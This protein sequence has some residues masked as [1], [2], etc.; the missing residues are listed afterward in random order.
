M[1]L[2]RFLLCLLL[3]PATLCAADL[4]YFRYPAI[5][6][7][8]LVFTAEGDVWV[9]DAAGGYGGRL[10][11]HPTLEYRKAI[12]PDG[13]WLAFNAGYEGPTEVYVM[14]VSGGPPKRLTFDDSY[15]QV[16]GWTPDGKILGS[17]THY[18]AHRRNMQLIEIDPE[19]TSQTLI[20]LAQAAEGAWNDHKSALYF[21]RF[22][23]QSSSTKRYK[24]G[25]AQNLWKWVPGSQE[26]IPLTADY[27]GTSRSPM[28]CQGRCYFVSDRDDTM[29]LWSMNADGGDLRQHTRHDNFDV[30]EP[31]LGQ[32]R[33]VY[34][35]GADLR[36][37]HIA[38]D[39]DRRVE[40][41]L[42]SDFLQTREKWIEEPVK[43]LS[44]MAISP[45]GDQLALVSRGQLFVTPVNGGRIQPISRKQGVRYRDVSFSHDGNSLI[46]VS[47][48]SGDYEFWQ[49]D[50]SGVD[51]R[52]QLTKDGHVLRFDPLVSPDGSRIVW[53][54]KNLKLWTYDF[55]TEHSEQIASSIHYSFGT[56]TYSPNGK[57]LAWSANDENEFSR[58]WIY[59]FETKE[60]H[61]LTSDRIDAHSPAW[62]R[63]GNRLFFVVDQ[64]LAS[65]V[66]SPW[67]MRQ[68]E[69]FFD[70][71][72]YI[73]ELPLK[74]GLRSIYE[75]PNEANRKFK[76]VVSKDYDFK[77]LALRMKRVPVPAG[78]Y[79]DLTA[80]A[81]NLFFEHQEKTG[82]KQTVLRAFKLASEPGSVRNLI[83]N[84]SEYELSQDGRKVVARSGTNLYVFDASIGGG[85]NSS[86]SQVKLNGW[87]F[88]IDPREEWKQMFVDAWRM[89]RDYFYDRGLHGV[90]W[91]A[92]LNR[93]LPLV[94]RVTDRSELN[95]LLTQIVGELEALHMTVGGGDYRSGG[96]YI[97]PGS[98]GV[99]LLRDEAA[100]GY[101]V[102][103]LPKWETDYPHEAPP[104]I[105]AD[106]DVKVG[107]VIVEIDNIPVLSVPHPALLLREKVS[108]DV[109]LDLRS[110]E[111]GKTRPVLVQP[112]YNRYRGSSTSSY[113]LLRYHEWKLTRRQ[114][115]DRESNEDIGYIHL[116]AMTT[117]DYASW[118]QQ[119]FPVFNRKG[120]I[121]DVRYNS[122][123]N[124]DSWILGRLLR[125]AWFYWKP[126][127]G[128]PYWNMHHA[129]RGHIVVLCNEWTAS[130]GEAFSEGIRR[131]GI[132]T[133]IGTRTWGGEIWLSRNNP[134]V[135]NG[136]AT[137]AQLGVFADGEWLIE[138][139]GVEPDIVVDNLPHETFL[140]RDRQLEVA[141][142]YLQKKIAEEPIEDPVV[143]PYYRREDA[144]LR[145]ETPASQTVSDADQNAEN[146]TAD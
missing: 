117:S 7:D 98:L 99:E 56:I 90:D 127:V 100:G 34:Q 49:F 38:D 108:Q 74:S 42:V 103:Y 87:K 135:D 30:L 123:G 75:K 80:S 114:Q 130:D 69:P 52:K 11:T 120:L 61:V 43:Y 92:E 94:D 89:E 10:T 136:I 102:S 46:V 32:G 28:W 122:G 133:V 44:H 124:I 88:S 63:D 106:P 1:T 76:P 121:I 83:N 118:A 3:F 116:S 31:S 95:D 27:E 129:F 79:G 109:L 35:H 81:Q 139:R 23:K 59:N 105:Q 50:L 107:D 36:I 144:P 71:V 13:K 85:I 39:T 112:I 40:I 60:K 143:P 54:D 97:S 82:S 33:I 47:D 141:I 68:P 18:S 110:A 48:E 4:G 93:F 17:T 115:V 51:Q 119:Y 55:K 21:T 45:K 9:V 73:Y 65:E 2:R 15:I 25:T 142:E 16:Q 111:T 101:R 24:G 145:A 29:N 137:A 140:G 91:D 126:R 104:L 96:D 70:D 5:H 20:P 37:Y 66:S 64:R 77:N 72:S 131:L 67:G 14:P 86:S 8:T 113:D 84:V 62:S 57:W 53:E 125:K 12:S 78:N 6:D 19:T 132:G 138:G 41:E 134:L 22:M 58:I 146:A 128:K 26:A